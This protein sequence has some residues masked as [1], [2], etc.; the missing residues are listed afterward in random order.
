MAWG[1]RVRR[2][3]LG[4]AEEEHVEHEI[5]VDGLP[6]SHRALLAERKSAH[7]GQRRSPPPRRRHRRA[8]VSS[9]AAVGW[10]L[11]QVWQPAP[12]TLSDGV[13]VRLQ[14]EEAARAVDEQGAGHLTER[15]AIPSFL[16]FCRLKEGKNVVVNFS[17][18]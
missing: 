17:S 4:S 16:I 12:D 5:A 14:R 13:H 8:A 6:A 3:V 10:L 7:E 11:A 18:L 9:T 1:G 2:H 15:F